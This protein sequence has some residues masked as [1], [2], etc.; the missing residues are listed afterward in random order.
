MAEEQ[1]QMVV[2][3]PTESMEQASEQR[4]DSVSSDEYNPAPAVQHEVSQTD[5]SPPSPSLAPS[6]DGI[7]MKTPEDKHPSSST[8]SD[9]ANV[10]PSQP[11]TVATDTLAGIPNVD[12]SMEPATSTSK[13]ERNHR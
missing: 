8:V 12:G 6:H 2:E 3:Q 9:I 10:I 13:A 1:T 5:P 11:A 7:V 4:A